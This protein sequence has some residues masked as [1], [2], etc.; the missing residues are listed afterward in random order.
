MLAAALLGAIGG[1]ADHSAKSTETEFL[2]FQV[3]G[4]LRNP[5]VT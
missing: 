4:R 1:D 2:T 5:V 3:L